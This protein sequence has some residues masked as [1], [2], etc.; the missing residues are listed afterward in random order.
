LV[1][2]VVVLV[3]A[4]AAGL[5]LSRQTPTYST[6]LTAR[7]SSLA[8][9]AMSSG[10]IGTAS[11]DFNISSV[12]SQEV[13]D[14]AAK[15]AKEPAT[16][17][18]SW[19][20]T[21]EQAQ[22]SSNQVMIST[23][24]PT[25]RS[26]Q[27]RATSVAH[28][29]NA[30]LQSQMAKAREAAVKQASDATA[31]AQAY[32]AQVNLND[33]NAVAQANLSAAI[34]ALT[35]ANKTISSLDGAPAPLTISTG[36]PLGTFTGVSPMI[37]IAVAL[38]AGLVAGI[39]I[40]L[41]WD[42]FD[43]R[44]RDDS[45]VEDA[46]GVPALGGL[47]LDRRVARGR[48]PLPAAGRK[49]TA[50][51]EDL[52]ALR[53]T[54]QVLLPPG[55]NVVVITSV[56]PGDGKTFISANL[57]LAWAR[58]GKR[59]ILVGGDLRKAALGPYYGEASDGAGLT[60]LLQGAVQQGTSPTPAAVEAHLRSTGFRGLRVLPSGAEPYDPADLLAVSALHDVFAALRQMSDIVIVDSPPSISLVDASLLAAEADGAVVVASVRRTK[61]GRLAD[62]VQALRSNG[63][64]VLGVVS[65][66]SRR[67]LP[68][69]YAAYYGRSAPRTTSRRTA[70]V[71]DPG[72]P[73]VA[74]EYPIAADEFLV[75]PASAF[76][77]E[78]A[79][80]KHYTIMHEAPLH[81]SD[82]VSAENESA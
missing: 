33:A 32:Q 53:T 37:A 1:V 21:Y 41:I 72:H 79:P 68:R 10:Q 60:E 2:I 5:F 11:V 62:T 39:G 78:R 38:V 66:R 47:S 30:Y 36:A 51:N 67:R 22:D 26:A 58:S 17:V 42:Q 56:E 29:Y 63:A 14:A 77:E 44:L 19:D 81:E 45:D 74:D 80:R 8:A 6:S 69:S 43:D 57:A 9:K 20:V 55:R 4:C 65:N 12:T 25:A 75:S 70:V 54:L 61:R 7:L 13:L 48:D 82:G 49:R 46:A 64:T 3:A 31:K 23:V 18:A 40:A 24:G 28:A 52:R 27:V 15:L 71:S 76:D 35:S 34:S 59:V 16:D 50:L 73:V